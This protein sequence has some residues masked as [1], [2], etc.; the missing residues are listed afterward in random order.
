MAKTEVNRWTIIACIIAA[1]GLFFGMY[2]YKINDVK[3]DTKFREKILVNDSLYWIMF[4][5]Q[6]G[7]NS[8]TNKRIDN[9]I[10]TVKTVNCQLLALMRKLDEKLEK[11]SMFNQALMKEVKGMQKYDFILKSSGTSENF[12]PE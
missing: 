3:S 6:R 11:Q 8:N 10:D 9:L 1:I 4:D 12:K 2:Q 7:I 5:A